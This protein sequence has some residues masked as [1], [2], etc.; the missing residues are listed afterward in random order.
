[1]DLIEHANSKRRMVALVTAFAAVAAGIVFSLMIILEMVLP[2][3]NL[4]PLD[5][6]K[7]RTF[8]LRFKL[9]V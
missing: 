9:A 8:E 5:L 3:V 2:T 7:S 6:T 1:M 4:G